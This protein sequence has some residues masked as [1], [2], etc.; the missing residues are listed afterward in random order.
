MNFSGKVALVTGSSRGIGRAIAL[1][2]AEL[3]ADV[4][5]N[6]TKLE[7]AKTVSKE[8]E[9]MGR[10]SFAV[11]ADVSNGRQ[12][13]DML[14]SAIK[15]FD[16]VDILVNNAGIVNQ[17]SLLNLEEK[18]WDKLISVD[19]KGVFLCSK[20]AA[21]Y[22]AEQKYGK[23]V[24]IASVAGLMSFQGLAHYCSAKAAV[25]SF[26]KEIALELAPLGIN[27]NAI[28]PG[29]IETDMTKDIKNNPDALNAVL[30]RI[31]MGRLGK[32]EEIA[33]AAAFLVSDEAS[34]I[35]GATLVVDGGWTTG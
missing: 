23:I 21:K 30:S 3:G 6:S 2:L 10:D 18:Q 24:N 8:I 17:G 12:V 9:S 25:I 4:I 26:T 22:M 11:Q 27:V 32:P 31:P 20:G 29:A 13:R 19:L 5:V 14:D 16:K 28:A 7:S 35:T 33:S 34:Y 1:K 15:K